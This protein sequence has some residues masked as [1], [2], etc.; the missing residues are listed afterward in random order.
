MKTSALIMFWYAVHLKGI[1]ILPGCNWTLYT[2]SIHLSLFTVYSAN[3]QHMSTFNHSALPKLL[4][5][6]HFLSS[7]K[8]HKIFI[9]SKHD[10]YVITEQ[11][12]TRISNLQESEN[13]YCNTITCIRVCYWV[14]FNMTFGIGPLYD[15]YSTLYSL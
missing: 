3:S 9:H 8:R 14:I 1:S 12:K 6:S 10:H 13:S 15:A 2:N 7:T 5:L 11:R 4:P